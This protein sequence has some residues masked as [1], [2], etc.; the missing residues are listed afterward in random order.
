MGQDDRDHAI[1]GD[2]TM[3]QRGLPRFVPYPA[4]VNYQI[5]LS[6]AYLVA[7]IRQGAFRSGIHYRKVGYSRSGIR[8]FHWS[9]TALRQWQRS[10]SSLQRCPKS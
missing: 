8:Y 1:P 7:L 6:E 3:P 10:S 4:L 5:P 9:P 2:L